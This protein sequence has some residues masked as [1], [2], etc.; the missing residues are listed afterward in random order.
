MERQTYKQVLDKLA[1]VDVWLSDLGFPKKANRIYQHISNICKLE[2]SWRDETLKKKFLNEA[3]HVQLFWSLIEAAEFADTYI[4]LRDF[5]PNS[6]KEKLREVLKGPADPNEETTT[7]SIGRN[8]MFE[9]NLASRLFC[10]GVPVYLQTNPDIFCEVNHRKIYIQCKRPFIER[11]IPNNISVARKQLTRDLN[12]SGDG[13]ARGV[14]A[15]SVSHTLNPG[16][17]L[18]IAKTYEEMKG[19]L[20]ITFRTWVISIRVL[21][22]ILLIREL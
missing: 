2:E 12:D 4:A 17:K 21:G 19:L 3:G 5:D 8:T 10:C 20:V 9:L 14:I 6:L 22:R 18:F 16:D 13:H 7:S 1:G 15:I 11:N